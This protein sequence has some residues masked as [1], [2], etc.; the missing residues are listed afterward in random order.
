M[1]DGGPQIPGPGVA[2]FLAAAI[3]AWAAA[4]PGT[5][6]L[7]DWII[8]GGLVLG[9]FFLGALGY[10]VEKLHADARLAIET[11]Q[12]TP[13]S[14]NPKSLADEPDSREKMSPEEATA[15]AEASEQSKM[16]TTRSDAEATLHWAR[17]SY[18][19]LGISVLVVAYGFSTTE[20]LTA[21][22][23]FHGLIVVLGSA[24]SCVWLLIQY[25]S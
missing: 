21:A 24:L 14:G 10:L 12:S 20:P 17:N 9:L 18:F 5:S 6:D 8:R 11:R 25:R 2:A 4:Q 15:R 23:I 3:A 1:S 13:Q 7:G 19:L 16:L 22:R